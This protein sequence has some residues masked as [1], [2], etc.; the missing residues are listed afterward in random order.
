MTLP[1]KSCKHTI[2]KPGWRLGLGS[3]GLSLATGQQITA[4]SAFGKE[5]FHVLLHLAWKGRSIELSSGPGHP[6]LTPEVLLSKS[7]RLGPFEPSA[8][9]ERMGGANSVETSE[10]LAGSVLMQ[11]REAL[12]LIPETSQA[13]GTGTLGPSAFSIWGL[14]GLLMA[15][16]FQV[17]DLRDRQAAEGRSHPSVDSAARAGRPPDQTCKAAC[18]VSGLGVSGSQGFFDSGLGFLCSLCMCSIFSAQ[19]WSL[20]TQP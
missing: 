8:G 11:V 9:L 4:N 5:K 2:L 17:P 6:T 20:P 19:T 10:G 16:A 7:L 15:S 12:D 3:A 13:L 14:R 1:C 18:K